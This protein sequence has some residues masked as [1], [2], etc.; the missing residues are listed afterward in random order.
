MTPADLTDNLKIKKMIE[1]TL[2]KKLTAKKVHALYDWDAE[3]EEDLSIKR[4][5]ALKIKERSDAWWLVQNESKQMGLV[6]RIFIQ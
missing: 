6:P 5:E 1:E 2:K 4:G 3:S